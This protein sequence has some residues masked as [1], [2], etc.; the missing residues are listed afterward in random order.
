M[1]TVGPK[2]MQ[3]YLFHNLSRDSLSPIS[4]L[5]SHP[6][7]TG[8]AFSV[9]TLSLLIQNKLV[10]LVRSL[11]HLLNGERPSKIEAVWRASRTSHCRWRENHAGKPAQRGAHAYGKDLG[12]DSW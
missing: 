11:L 1:H 2:Q 4:P 7:Q 9:L 5:A 6:E 12:A 3:P 8:G 10:E